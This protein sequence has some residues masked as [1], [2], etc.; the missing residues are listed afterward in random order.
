MFLFQALPPVRSKIK[1]ISQDQKS[2]CNA[3]N[4][5]PTRI[6]GCNYAS[7]DKFDVVSFVLLLVITSPL[8]N[9]AGSTRHTMMLPG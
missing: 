4:Q 6:S 5:R 7:W 1:R 3:E 8:A 2:R 9:V